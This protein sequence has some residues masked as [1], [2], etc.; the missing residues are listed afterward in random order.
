MTVCFEFVNEERIIPD[1]YAAS[2]VSEFQNYNGV[3]IEVRSCD[4]KT[5]G[6]EGATTANQRH[7]RADPGNSLMFDP[8]TGKLMVKPR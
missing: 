3:S 8:A 6:G 2:F 4:G 5:K 1:Q 7:A